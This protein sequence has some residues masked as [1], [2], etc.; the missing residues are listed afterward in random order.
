VFPEKDNGLIVDYIGVFRDLE[1]ALAIYGAATAEAGV[2]SPIQDESELVAAL[3]EAVEEVV[4]LCALYDIDLDELRQASGFAFI[5]LRDAAGETFLAD[6]ELRL[7]FRRTSPGRR[8][9]YGKSRH[10]RGMG[11]HLSRLPVRRRTRR[12]GRHLGPDR[13]NDAHQSRP[14]LGRRVTTHRDLIE[15]ARNYKGG[16]TSDKLARSALLGS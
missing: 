6:E 2:D 5:A 8:R 14:A 16:T 10:T 4:D 3:G 15:T 13:D 9:T 12:P 11:L 1:R 7:C